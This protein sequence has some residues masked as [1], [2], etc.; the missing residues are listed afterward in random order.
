MVMPEGPTAAF[1]MTATSC[2][3]HTHQMLSLGGQICRQ[4][5]AKECRSK[6]VWFPRVTSAPSN[7]CLA[8]DNSP[9][10]STRMARCL[11]W[12]AP[13]HSPLVTT[14]FG[15]CGHLLKGGAAK[16][17]ATSRNL[18]IPSLSDRILAG[19]HLLRNQLHHVPVRAL[20]K[21]RR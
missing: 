10:V 18:P 7:T 19:Q 20:Q 1:S 12:S 17:V 11:I 6:V 13:L 4:K 9:K 8:W 21:P 5:F 16:C 3:T 15:K 14:C 2:G